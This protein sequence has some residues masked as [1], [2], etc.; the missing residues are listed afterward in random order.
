MCWFC[1]FNYTLYYLYTIKQTN[2]KKMKNSTLRKE[3]NCFEFNTKVYDLPSTN[4]AESL[5]FNG[6]TLIVVTIF[7]D[8]SQT[9]I[10]TTTKEW[11]Y[12]SSR[13]TDYSE[14]YRK[15]IS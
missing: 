13:G 10:K 2:T 3:T 8:D 6:R 4:K 15:T 12:T 5:G 7:T 11:R 14:T 9:E 1:N